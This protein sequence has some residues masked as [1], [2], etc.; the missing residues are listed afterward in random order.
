MSTGSQ[1]RDVAD[2]REWKDLN[3]TTE[4]RPHAFSENRDLSVTHLWE[5]PDVKNVILSHLEAKSMP[6]SVFSSWSHD[7][8]TA[9]SWGDR[10]K[11]EDVY[12]SIMDRRNLDSDVMV[13]HV[14]ELQQAGLI[15]LPNEVH[16]EYLV[17]GPVSGPG[18]KCISLNDLQS[19]GIAFLG[20]INSPSKVQHGS[21][22][23]RAIETVGLILPG[24]VSTKDV[25]LFYFLAATFLAPDLSGLSFASTEQV[26]EWCLAF[27]EE[28][29][30]QIDATLPNLANDLRNLPLLVERLPRAYQT[31]SLLLA[32]TQFVH[33]VWGVYDDFDIEKLLTAFNGPFRSGT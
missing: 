26:K 6:L 4:I 3:S 5:V 20:H 9:I 18:L 31:A 1:S 25:P 22:R 32:M 14:I 19:A 29:R 33:T 13:Y 12:I 30:E 8:D 21:I 10:R 15:D 23:A 27:T 11:N 16:F 17:H 24:N 7:L 28:I 2:E